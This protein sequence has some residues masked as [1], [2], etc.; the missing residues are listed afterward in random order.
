LTRQDNS[1]MATAIEIFRTTVL[2][3]EDDLAT[4]LQVTDEDM[5]DLDRK[6]DL[7]MHG[8]QTVLSFIR[9]FVIL[10]WISQG[11]YGTA[12]VV[13]WKDIVVNEL[14]FG[15]EILFYDPS[16]SSSVLLNLMLTA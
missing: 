9:V 11:N 13:Y 1:S 10:L 7:I 8:K 3:D 12:N 15:Y 6:P 4:S 5:E 14:Y 2:N 16:K